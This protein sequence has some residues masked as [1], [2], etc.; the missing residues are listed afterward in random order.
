KGTREPVEARLVGGERA[1]AP[2]R[3]SPLVGREWELAEL[4]RIL[5]D[6]ADGRGAVVAITGEAGIGKSRLV[7]E[8]RERSGDEVRFLGA[9]GVS[10]AREI[11]Y[12]P[13]RE[14][15]RGFLELGVGDPETRV[16]LALKLQ[17]TEPTGAR[18][19]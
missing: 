16:R 17:L 15:L 4:E 18:A 10:Y 6:L 2:R 1:A 8:A 5:R 11:P 19:A 12:Y 3:A 7:S 13:F 9:Q 14:L